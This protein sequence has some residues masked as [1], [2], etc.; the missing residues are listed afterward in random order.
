MLCCASGRMPEPIIREEHKIESRLFRNWVNELNILDPDADD[1]LDLNLFQA[2]LSNIGDSKAKDRVK[3]RS[4]A[5]ESALKEILDEHSD[6]LEYLGVEVAGWPDDG[7]RYRK[8][9]YEEA[10]EFV[11]KMKEGLGEYGPV[12][13][14]SADARSGVG[15]GSN[16]REVG[17]GDYRSG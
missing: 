11:G 6:D 17:T 10:R 2:A 16:P 1:W 9:T 12:R 15:A 5:V 4:G 14:A 7:K 13:P 3:A 8:S